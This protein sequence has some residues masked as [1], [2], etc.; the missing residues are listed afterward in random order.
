MNGIPF[1]ASTALMSALAL[2]GAFIASGAL[3]YWLLPGRGAAPAFERNPANERVRDAFAR[4]P[5]S[6]VPNAG[7]TD[8][9]V[10]YYAQGPGYGFYFTDDKA[11]L[12][13][14]DQAN[15]GT[16]LDLRFIGARQGAA[17]KAHNLRA[18]KVSYL[19]GNDPG[20]WQTGLP[21]YGQVVYEELWPG[22]DARFQG[23]K[24]EL[25]YEFAV[26]P[27]ARVEDIRLAY[28]GAK[29]LSLGKTGQLLIQTS[30]GALTDALPRSYQD[31]GGRRVPVETRYALEDGSG[32][33]I[34]YGFDVGKGYDPRYPLVIDPGLAYSTYL[35]SPGTNPFLCECG[36]GIAIDEEGRAFVSGQAPVPDFPT[37]AGAFQE[38]FQGG[39]DGG[40]D[41]FL[42]VLDPDASGS[43]SL[44]YSTYIGGSNNDASPSVALGKD[45]H[46][47]VGVGTDSSDFPI[48]DSAY[49][50]E[51]GGGGF[52]AAIVELDLD[53]SGAD[54]LV[55]SSYLGGS[56]FDRGPSV[57][58]GPDGH[59]FLSTR[60]ASTD[61][62][63]TPGAFQAEYGGGALDS[64]LAEF[65]TSAAGEDSLVY[66]TYLGGS[67]IDDREGLAADSQ[68]RVVISGVTDS[69]NFPVTPT[70]F[71]GTKS[72]G[73]DAFV[74]VLD[75]DAVGA[76]GLVY[77]SYLGGG[78]PDAAA[79]VAVGGDGRLLLTGATGS[80][81]AGGSASF[82]VTASAFQG[83]YGGGARDGFL[84]KL[85][86][87]AS[88]NA[89]LLYATYLGG[90]ATDTSGGVAVNRAGHAFI[91]G[92]ASSVNF[93]VTADAFQGSYGGGL[94]D[95]FVAELDTDAFGGASLVYSTY[96]GG[97]QA[98]RA[99]IAGD[100]IAVDR[101]GHA[102][103][104]G[105]TNSLDFPVTDGAFQ[106]SYA[107]GGS[108]DVFLVKFRRNK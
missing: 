23:G 18:A 70:A 44:L 106:S 89:S 11:V 108:N 97:S 107:G 103:V 38:S 105:D 83:T 21:T 57:T 28:G 94:A 42:A 102:F 35:G 69:A 20:K 12:S 19:R 49:Q 96:L 7:Q 6:F 41:A 86:P 47:I 72:G 4:L 87:T 10:R 99:D 34:S 88:G 40:G 60:T 31:I 55:Y 46:V 48:T 68:G 8:A 45:G 24:G 37:T 71:Q 82:P 29:G 63:T 100:M 27:G 81:G 67:G 101:P 39:E 52:D 59:V 33:E 2:A 75:P 77:S 17:L 93:P 56:D 30:L 25:K 54:V 3:A 13:F 78:G 73:T 43:D 98:D 62:E 16:V 50:S 104:T 22:I 51:L 76:A 95:A 14:S 26:R 80:S 74:T 1:R 58:V 84:A 90:S 64:F 36:R 66:A 61:I 5:L 92:R 91:A 65:D 32:G 79:G 15:Q 9:R 85:D 53:A